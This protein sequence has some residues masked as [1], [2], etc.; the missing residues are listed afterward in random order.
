MRVAAALLEHGVEY[1]MHIFPKGAHGLSLGDI[2]TACE[3][4]HIEPTATDWMNLSIKWLKAK[5]NMGM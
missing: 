4:K 3:P 1:E 5:T 2:T